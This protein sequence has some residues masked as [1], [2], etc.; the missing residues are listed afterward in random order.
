MLNK[1]NGTPYLLL[2][3]FFEKYVFANLFKQK[4]VNSLTE[5]FPEEPVIAMLLAFKDFLKFE[6]K[7]LK[8]SKGFFLKIIFE[9]LYFLLEIDKIALFLIASSAY[10]L[11]S[12][13][14]PLTPIKIEFLNIFLEFIDAYFI[15][16][17]LSIILFFMLSFKIFVLID[18]D[19]FK[20]FLFIAFKISNLSEK[21]NFFLYS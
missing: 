11:P 5:V 7:L 2:N 14:F 8:K 18:L 4:P 17:F 3:E 16:L 9:F 15:N 10:I 6:L 12:N 19:K 13:F 20:F 1:L 21:N